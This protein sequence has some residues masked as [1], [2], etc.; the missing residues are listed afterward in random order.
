MT[1]CYELYCYFKNHDIFH[2]DDIVCKGDRI[3][4]YIKAYMR[5]L[6][7]KGVKFDNTKT[8][9][10]R[11]KR[12]VKKY[13]TEQSYTN[14][15]IMPPLP[16]EPFD[17]IYA[18]PPWRY[19]VNHLRANP[20]KHYPTLPLDEILKLEVPTSENAVLFLWATNPMLEDALEVMRAW[21]FNYKTNFAWEKD[22]FGTGFYNR[23]QHELLLIGVKGDV[24]PPGESNRFPS[25]IK[26]KVREHS[27]KPEEA[28]EIIEKMYPNARYLELFARN[29]R[30]GWEAWGNEV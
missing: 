17:I 20:E 13:G 5:F 4:R 19:Y 8:D 30:S 12:L 2:C 22:K 10:A 18:D 27:R 7:S 15:I 23:G 6:M 24:H 21:G 1:R 16:K 28:Y 3:K 26:A 29:K 14:G 9:K 11:F 25:I